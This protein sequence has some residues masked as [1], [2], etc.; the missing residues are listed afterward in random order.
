MAAAATSVVAEPVVADSAR[1]VAPPVPPEEKPLDPRQIARA[2]LAAGRN[3][4]LWWVSAGV[5]TATGIA[6][7]AGMSWGALFLAVMLVAGA[8]AR[9]V[10]SGDHPA[11][12]AVRSRPVDVAVL[13][14][15]AFVVG[16][17]S[18]IVPAG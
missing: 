7:L 8:V 1:V 6:L 2:S 12:L 4:S 17:L 18:Q 3:A 5:V 16:V 15:F 14:G 11:A 10:A 13:L 9:A